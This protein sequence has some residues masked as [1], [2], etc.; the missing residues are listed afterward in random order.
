VCR[1]RGGL[2]SGIHGPWNFEASFEL[3][4]CR[5]AG[6]SQ[7]EP[8]SV[9]FI[10]DVVTVKRPKRP[11]RDHTILSCVLANLLKRGIILGLSAF[12]VDAQR[13]GSTV[14][15]LRLESLNGRFNNDRLRRRTTAKQPN[16]IAKSDQFRPVTLA[17][18]AER[19]PALLIASVTIFLEAEK[20]IQPATVPNLAA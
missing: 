17:F 9:E 10:L 19:K 12:H 13:K 20:T 16:V 11:V 3:P 4:L 6:L 14:V 5:C 2:A 8:L 1:G 7:N 15:L 18:I